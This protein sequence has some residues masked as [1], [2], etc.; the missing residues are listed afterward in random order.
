MIYMNPYIIFGVNYNIMEKN[1][2]MLSLES[3]ASIAIQ[4]LLDAYFKPLGLD[5]QA[6][7]RQGAATWS[8]YEDDFAKCK[9]NDQFET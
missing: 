6:I 1:F 8:T 2:K 3:K 4:T 9:V 5:W 7:A